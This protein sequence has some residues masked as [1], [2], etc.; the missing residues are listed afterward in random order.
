MKKRYHDP[1]TLDWTL[2][3]WAPEFWRMQHTMEI[4]ASPDAEVRA[5]PAKV[6]G[7]VQY[8][9]REAGV[10]PDWNL[11]MNYRLCEW[12]ENRHW[13]YETTLPDEWFAERRAFRLNC[14]GLDYRGTV[15]VNGQTIGE[16]V[17]TQIPHVFDITPF[18]KDSGN[19]LAIV[20][21]CAPRWLGQF[22]LTSKMTEWKPRF[23]YS[24]DWVC[25]LVQIGIW[26]GIAIEVVDD[27][28]I[29]SFRCVAD[30]DSLRVW[31][32][33]I[34]GHSV[35]IV[36]S[37]GGRL[38]CEEIVSPAG[39][40]DVKWDELDVEPWNPNMGGEQPLYDLTCTLMG[41]EIELDSASRRVGFR[42]VEWR[43]C[44]GAP[45]GADPWVC[46]VNGKPVFLQGA[47]WTPIRANFA[48]VTEADYRERLEL[49]QDLG[50]NLL[51]VWG[52][53]FLENG[54]VLR[55]LRRAWADGVAGVSAV[56]FGRGE[57]AA[58]R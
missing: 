10:I 52:G 30:G 56:E 15:L 37:K 32:A 40:F 26:G 46:V 38:L 35:K 9:L 54:D 33:A 36:L 21:E 14:R 25:R 53:G 23:N 29:E 58:G 12:V 57:L 50:C 34:G 19:R 16:F 2:S 18:I 4:G 7:S 47:N 28:E 13:I 42:R 5:V 6:P 44:E 45:E 20:F 11:G 27:A 51:R 41:D 8:S 17:G 39:E 31:G 43:S 49:Y 24:W 1:L 55:P 3:G 48:D 22:G